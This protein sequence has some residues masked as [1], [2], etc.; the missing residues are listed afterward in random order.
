MSRR[1]ACAA[2]GVAVLLTGCT[3]DQ[4]PSGPDQSER[5]PRS[6]AAVALPPPGPFDYQLGGPYA[7]SEG[8]GTVVR[9]S[10]APTLNDAYNV[11]YVNAFQT[12]PGKA[13]DWSG[14][15]LVDAGEPVMD[16]DWPDEAVLD[17]S[18]AASREAI[19]G[20]LAPVLE[21]CADAG[22]DAVEFDNLDSYQR[23]N[24]LLSTADNAALA[25]ALIGIAH[26]LGLAAAQKNA[27]ELLGERLDFDFAIT[28]ECGAF[29][30]C[31]V[32]EKRYDRVL[33]IEY[34]PD[35]FHAACEAGALPDDA[36]LRDVDLV[37]DADGAYAYE[38]C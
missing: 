32:F 33:D 16:P 30:E 29:D 23:S 27:A 11:C 22:F 3:S 24:G 13:D 8:V 9:D 5:M 34:A 19:A 36:I 38:K 37:A 14:L 6:S 2:L 20:R 25:D 18:T 17:T 35:A 26:G 7:P 31:A 15:V 21:G 1:V 12:Q 10:T 4:T 28:E